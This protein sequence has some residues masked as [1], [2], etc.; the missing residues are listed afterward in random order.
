MSHMISKKSHL[1]LEQYP[2]GNPEYH[3]A[4]FHFFRNPREQCTA[5]A[6]Q[7]YSQRAGPRKF[8][9]AVSKRNAAEQ[10]HPKPE[11][12]RHHQVTPAI[13]R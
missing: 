11:S 6:Q 2:D 3:Q 12:L 10:F 9:A 1:S 8:N 5:T 13:A 4:E 7:E